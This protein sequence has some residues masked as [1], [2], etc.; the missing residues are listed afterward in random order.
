MDKLKERVADLL[1]KATDLS[2]RTGV[3]QISIDFGEDLCEL[4]GSF[5][6]SLTEE[7]TKIKNYIDE[8]GSLSYKVGN[9]LEVTREDLKS[10]IDAMR[11]VLK[12]SDEM[13]KMIKEL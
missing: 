5:Q 7:K 1:E 3:H 12:Y 9:T 8:F 2:Y 4:L 13:V 10:D 11:E 6:Y